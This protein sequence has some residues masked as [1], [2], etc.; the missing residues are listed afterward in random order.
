M[1][2]KIVKFLT[3]LNILWAVGAYNYMSYNY[4]GRHNDV[5]PILPT[6]EFKTNQIFAGRSLTLRERDILFLPNTARQVKEVLVGSDEIEYES[7]S[8]KN[9]DRYSISGETN[10]DKTRAI[11][12][13][14]V[15]MLR[16]PSLYV[17]EKNCFVDTVP[18]SQMPPNQNQ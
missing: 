14:A 3:L 15:A 8:S 12:N 17:D 2:L 4:E 5:L 16:G 1:K 7:S 11:R 10:D 13:L 6:Q 9:S 18:L